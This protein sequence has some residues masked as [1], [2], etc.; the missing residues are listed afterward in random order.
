MRCSSCE[1]LL[2]DYLDATLSRRQMRDVVLH[3]NWCRLC[4]ALLDELRV[5]DALL[6][7]ARSARVGS[8]FTAAVV[9][10][11]SAAQ[12]PAR[13]GIPLW[14]PMLAYLVAAWALAAVV[15]LRGHQ[16]TAVLGAF[17][18][19]ARGGLAAIEAV[20]RALAP[21]TAYA[22]AVV[23]GVLLLDLCLL[24]A[25]F[26]AYRRLRPALAVYLARGPRV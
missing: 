26:Y 10:A 15:G 19:Q 1:P 8:D 22:A 7:T 24:V 21:E 4:V 20:S 16:L 14:L 18:A 2:D 5:V 3:L 12:P 17:A 11:T 6:T 13:R 9:S 25:T 23:T